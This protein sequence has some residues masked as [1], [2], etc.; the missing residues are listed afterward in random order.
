MLYYA[1]LKFVEVSF[2]KGSVDV[3]FVSWPSCLMSQAVKN[4][5][6]NVQSSPCCALFQN[7]LD[8]CPSR[9]ISSVLTCFVAAVAELV[10][11]LCVVAA[12]AK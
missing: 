6:S 7:R 1:Q 3:F 9:V 11:R 8:C 5:G 10:S 12:G 4:C 2:G